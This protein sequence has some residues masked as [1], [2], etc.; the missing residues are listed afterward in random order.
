MMTCDEATI[1]LHALVD[2]ELDTDHAHEL[3]AHVGGCPNCAAELASVRQLHQRL[4]G[5]SLRRPAPEAL[6]RRIEAALPVH[7]APAVRT[8]ATS[9]RS[10]LKGFALGTALSAAAAAGVVVMVVRS[11]RDR[12]FL[13]DVV[14]AHLRS[15]QGEHLTD[16][17]SADQT[18]VKPWFSGR[19][20]VSPPVVDLAAQGFLLLGARLDTLDGKAVAALVY[21][22]RAHVINLFVTPSVSPQHT[23]LRADTVQGLNVGRWSDQ[24]LS[25]IAVSDINADELQEFHTKYETAVR[26]GA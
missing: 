25:F 16:M 22:R 15:L 23:P 13:G 8:V 1:M 21:K 19:L 24:G 6:R 4:S 17:A 11:D 2:G 26:A 3:E 18:A 5:A 12:R 14:S 7:S 9:R 10:L 20:A